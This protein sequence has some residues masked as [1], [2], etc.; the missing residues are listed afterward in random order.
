MAKKPVVVVTGSSTGIGL[1]IC[2]SLSQ[3]NYTVV[4]T[5]RT[6]SAAPESLRASGCDIHPLDV[7]SDTSAA[8]LCEYLRSTYSGCDV[9]IN[10]AG[11]ALPGT[12]ETTSIEA[13]KRVF[14]VNVW[15]AVRMCQVLVP[16]MRSRCGG[17]VVTVSSTSGWR[18]LPCSDVYAS[19]KHA[20]EGMMEC[21]R[22]SVQK[23]N[24]KVCIVN[25]GPTNTPFSKRSKAEWIPGTRAQAETPTLP[26]RLTEHY[27]EETER[28]N[29]AGQ[30]PEDCAEA[31]AK[32]VERE[33]PKKIDDG[34]E[35]ATFWNPT[36]DYGNDVLENTRVF[37]DGTSGPVYDS[38]FKQS[39][40]ILNK[41]QR[42]EISKGAPQH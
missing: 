26:M 8:S 4:A 11:W 32:V 42:E 23:D 9:L 21:F 1:N 3:R 16:F 37:K 18:G 2:L 17:L 33:L 38:Y 30:S 19:S 15:G 5:L 36:S 34:T 12:I 20:I 7:T 13:A 10:N 29:S 31:I 14:E 6:P 27:M 39:F 41:L 35:R 40:D 28:R 22:Y 25:P 24:I